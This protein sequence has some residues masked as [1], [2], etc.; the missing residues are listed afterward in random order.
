MGFFSWDCLGCGESVKAPFDI[1]AE[2]SW[3]GQ[4]VAIEPGGSPIIGSYDGYGRVYEHEADARLP[5]P[6]RTSEGVELPRLTPDGEPDLSV[7]HLRCWKACGEPS[8]SRPS[9]NA[10]D[11]GFFYPRGGEVE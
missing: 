2:I 1:P 10:S 11:Q 9:P 6:Q 4:I 5:Q 3:H 8:H 7:W